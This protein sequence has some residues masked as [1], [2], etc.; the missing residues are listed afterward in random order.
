ML[1]K[2]IPFFFGV[3]GAQ[4]GVRVGGIFQREK[5]VL[6]SRALVGGNGIEKLGFVAVGGH[7][8]IPG[9]IQDGWQA[10]RSCLR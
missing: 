8:L 4:I 5:D 2:H 1:V 6:K 7:G 3:A 9:V 10:S